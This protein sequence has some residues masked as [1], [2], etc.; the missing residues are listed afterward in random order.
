MRRL[1]VVAIA[2]IA[3]SSH[4]FAQAPRQARAVAAVEDPI[5]LGLDG[6]LAFTLT[7]PHSTNIAIPVQRA[8]VGFFIS[9]RI[10]IEP[11]GALSYRSVEDISVTN[12]DLGVG[13]LY[14]WGVARGDPQPYVR[15]FLEL[16]HTSVSGDNASDGNTAFAL[17]FG[18]GV[19]IPITTLF[20]WRFEGALTEV[21]SHDNIDASTRLSGFFG[22][23]FFLY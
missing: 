17:G 3:L 4:A 21:F 18:A 5:E 8:R 1:V 10:S 6:V 9:P 11:Y 23:S 2:V 20:S 12:F 19:R 7:S 14:Q 16:N 13:G 22:I 15:P